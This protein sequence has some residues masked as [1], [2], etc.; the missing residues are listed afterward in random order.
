MPCHEVQEIVRAIAF[1]SLVLPI[2]VSPTAVINSSVMA[3]V[4]LIP[5]S[6][7][8]KREPL[9]TLSRREQA[10]GILRETEFAKSA[11]RPTSDFAVRISFRFLTSGRFHGTN[12]Y[13]VQEGWKRFQCRA[14][15]RG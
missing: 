11:N 5:T 3:S 4:C 1:F 12:V 14:E 8:L 6:T 7:S 13:P 2:Q 15:T 9:A 10:R